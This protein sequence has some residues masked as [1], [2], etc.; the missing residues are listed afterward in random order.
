MPIGRK[1]SPE[2]SLA[3]LETGKNNVPASDEL[4]PLPSPPPLPIQGKDRVN[5]FQS[6]LPKCQLKDIVLADSVRQE[7]NTLLSRIANH[8][9]IYNAWGFSKVD[10]QGKNIAV[11]FYGLPG[12]GK[13]ML[14]DALASA[15][16]KPIIEVN[17][18]EIESKYVGETAKNIVAAFNQ[19]KL[20][21]AVLFFDEADSI[22]GRRL[23]NVT[24]SADHGVNVSRSVMLKQ[25]DDFTGIVVFATNLAKNFDTAFVRRILQHV[26]V[27]PPDDKARLELWQIMITS[28][29]PGRASIDFD[30]LVKSSHGMTGGLIKNATLLALSQLADRK[31]PHRLIKN[32]DLLAAIENVKRAHEDVGDGESVS[33]WKEILPSQSNGLVTKVGPGIIES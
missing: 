30:T 25:L 18:A 3:S 10:P 23:T 11:N 13:T 8:D 2:E 26:H 29:V 27:L 31:E 5:Q 19:A 6:R 9:L 32:E 20:E 7:V 16:H 28:A 22:L 14:A 12:T 24:Q 33:Q 21:E 1:I 15:L 4:P 17:Y